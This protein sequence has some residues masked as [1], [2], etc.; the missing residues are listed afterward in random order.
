MNRLWVNVGVAAMVLALMAWLAAESDNWRDAFAWG[1]GSANYYHLLVDGLREGHLYLK[2][3]VHPGLL[4]SDASVRAQAPYL[5]DASLF[6]GRYYLYFGVVPA[7]LLF[8][9]FALVT[10]YHLAT[11]TAVLA[12]VALGFLFYVALFAEARRRY[13]AALALWIDAI[14]LLF[15]GLALP[16]PALL[17]SS[18]MYEVAIASGYLCMAVTWW[19]LF[20]AVHSATGPARWLAVSSIALGLAVGCR[21]NYIFAMPALLVAAWWRAYHPRESEIPYAPR[22][23]FFRLFTAAAVPAAVVGLLLMSYNYGRF[24]NPFEFGFRYQL[25]ELVFRHFPLAKASF[26]W[27]NLKWYYLTPPI[28]S[29]YFP[30]F[31]PLNATPLPPSYY[32]YE[33]IHGQWPI[34]LP[35][36]LAAVGLVGIHRSVRRLPPTFIWFLGLVGGVFVALFLGMAFFGFRADRY[37]VDFQ[38]TLVLAVVL[39]GGYGA[40]HAWLAGWRLRLWRAAFGLTAGACVLFNLFA[41]L[42]LFDRLAATH[43]TTYQFLAYYGNYPSQLMARWG[44]LH[45]GPIGFKA[46]FSPP[47]IRTTESLLTTGTFGSVDALYVT[48]HGNGQVSFSM[49]HQGHGGPGTDI[50]NM[51]Y[52]REYNI[53]VDMGSLYP[54]RMHPY[55]HGWDQTS[56]ER[57]KNT[58]RVLLDGVEVLRANLRFYD[59]PPGSIRFGEDPILGAPALFSRIRSIQ[60]LSP[61]NP[62]EFATSAENGLWRFQVEFPF[63]VQRLGQPVLGSGVAGRGN[64]LLLEVIAPHVLRF[65]YDQWGSGL[66]SS[67]PVEIAQAGPHSLEIF[68]GSQATRCPWPAEWR[69][70][71]ADLA[72][73][74]RLLRVWLDGRLVWTV[75]ILANADSYDLISIGS[76]PQGFSTAAMVFAGTLK[77]LPL[78]PDE[79]KELLTRNLRTAQSPQ[80]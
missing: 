65:G 18:R 16:L 20:R 31:L 40:A 67:Q 15:L 58:G 27:P 23:S 26:F 52:G 56:V 61:R 13:F 66:T 51:E 14:G 3:D 69:I 54:P 2:A 43:P 47:Q 30:Y 36:L 79:M 5:L 24:H 77:R 28:V 21:P 4:S 57:L 42:Q 74:A 44:L 75:P 68:V 70:D 39:L 50:L 64:L 53:E 11:N 62:A 60:Y 33:P 38:G 76:N 10:G 55:F 17:M 19:S 37:V 34:L 45:C 9:P 32:G 8:L 78:Q 7:V 35:T 72:R 6:H 12:M 80:P 73:S 22:R 59:A 1:D 29:P 49:V 25:S 71:R 46:I 48:H 63:H 41:G